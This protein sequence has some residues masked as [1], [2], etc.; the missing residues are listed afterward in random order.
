[1]K[2]KMGNGNTN[3]NENNETFQIVIR[4]LPELVLGTIDFS[5][6]ETAALIYPNPIVSETTLEYTLSQAETISITLY[7]VSGKLIRTFL[8][9]EEKEAGD[10]KQTL[11]FDGIATGNYVLKL[12]NGSGQ[13]SLQ[14]L[15]K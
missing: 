4:Y 10:H 5:I 2:L 9:S 15:K 14:I 12:S 11:N 6:S 1:M 7:D 8:S 3:R 13:F